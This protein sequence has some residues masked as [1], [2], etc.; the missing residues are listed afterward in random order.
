MSESVENRVLEALD[1]AADLG[2]AS[3]DP[4]GREKMVQFAQELIKWNRTFNLTS[5]TKPA[6]VAEL[7]VLDSLAIVPQL[8]SQGR[9]LDVGT[10]GGFPGIPAALARPD[11]EFVLVDRTEKKVLF[12]K[13]VIARMRLE[14][15]RAVHQRVDGAPQEEGLG[16]FQLVVSRAFAAPEVWL[17]LGAKYAEKDS[18]VLAMLGAERPDLDEL[19]D[20]IGADRSALDLI[21]YQ[22]PSGHQRAL[23]ILEVA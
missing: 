21:A 6:D 8:P 15:V 22:L 5:I 2:W 12:L 17:P 19:A 1:R 16:S 10:G 4:S 9:V 18:R 14:N 23:V 3:L 7:H 13:N 20:A 11:L